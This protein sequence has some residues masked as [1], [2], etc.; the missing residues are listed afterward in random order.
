M[1][2]ACPLSVVVM[3]SVLC[4]DDLAR[5][6][7]LHGTRAG[8]AVRRPGEGRCLYATG[9][10]RE[11]AVQRKRE[12]ERDRD[13]ETFVTGRMRIVSEVRGCPLVLF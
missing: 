8:A 7:A 13:G 10:E 3:S 2:P 1:T 11:G 4:Y 9:V 5:S 12:R 6:L